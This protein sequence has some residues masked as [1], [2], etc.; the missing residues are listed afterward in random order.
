MI[1]SG[2]ES[3]KEKADRQGHECHLLI[4]GVS[5]SKRYPAPQDFLIDK[6]LAYAW[7]DLV[8]GQADP[9]VASKPLLPWLVA[10]T[11]F[12]IGWML[13]EEDPYAF[14]ASPPRLFSKER[15]SMKSG[16]KSQLLIV[17]GLREGS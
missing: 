11:M 9:F 12:A 3:L 4:K 6:L 13:P 14:Q 2:P 16:L 10:M 5:K 17:F 15:R 1:L 7:P 8:P